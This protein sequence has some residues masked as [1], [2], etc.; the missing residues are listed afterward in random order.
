MLLC[1]STKNKKY[2]VIYISKIRLNN[3][4]FYDLSHVT[5]Y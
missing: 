5:Q 2:T 1:S 3:S 4:L